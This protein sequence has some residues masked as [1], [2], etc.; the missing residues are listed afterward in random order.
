[1]SDTL[2]A[3]PD[4][5]PEAHERGS[6]TRSPRSRRSCART[7]SSRGWSTSRPRTRPTPSA[8]ELVESPRHQ[9][10]PGAAAEPARPAAPGRHRLHPRGA[11]AR[12][13]AV[14]LG[15]RQGRARRR[16]PGRGL[17]RGPRVAHR[18]DG[19]RRAR[20]G[21]RDARRGRARG[22]RRRPPA[23]GHRRRLPEACR[24]RSASSCARRCPSR[25]TWSAR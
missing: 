20:R 2:E 17:R 14:R 1:M 18:L 16:D 19:H 13:A 6:R 5:R 9:A 22:D 7:A 25:R 23:G 12:R 15:P 11:A 21:R 24:S 3:K 8:R 10:E 4:D